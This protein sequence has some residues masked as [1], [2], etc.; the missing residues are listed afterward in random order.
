[1]LSRKE[2]GLREP[3]LKG[4]ALILRS[5]PEPQVRSAAVRAL[6]EA[7]DTDYLPNVVAALSDESAG[8]RWD[9]AAAMDQLVD[10]AAIDPLC[11]RATEDTSVDVRVAC[12]KALRHYPTERVFDTLV[13]LLSDPAFAVRHQARASLVEMTGRDFGLDPRA[14]SKVGYAA[15]T[16]EPSPVSGEHWYD[17]LRLDGEDKETSSSGE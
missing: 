11:E 10:V 13:V 17:F 2:W 16:P 1:M 5:D 8:V 3:Y 9:A 12:A 4:Y 15:L 6:G 14:W 7:G